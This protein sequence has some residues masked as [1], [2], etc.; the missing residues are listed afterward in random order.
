MAGQRACLHDV[1]RPHCGSNRM[2]KDGRSR[3][4]RTYR[5]G[6]CKRRLSGWIMD[7]ERSE[8]KPAGPDIPAWARKA[9]GI[10]ADNPQM[11]TVS[12]DETWTRVGARRGENRRSARI[13]TA[14]VEEWDGSRRVDFEVGYRD[15]ETFLRLFRRL[16]STGA[17]IARCTAVCRPLAA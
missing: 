13:W 3:G 7:A 15:A 8:R 14:A 12:F 6:D 17:T 10:S 5:C 9:R 11:K 16:R 4:K 1:R 2:P